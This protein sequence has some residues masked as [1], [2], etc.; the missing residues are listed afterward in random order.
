MTD[1]IIKKDYNKGYS[2]EFDGFLIINLIEKEDNEYLIIELTDKIKSFYNL[3]NNA[4]DVKQFTKDYKIK[5]NLLHKIEC[6]VYTYY[7]IQYIGKPT[8]I[9]M[10]LMNCLMINN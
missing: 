5:G 6:F 10:K 1:I 7:D 8:Y 3:K 4:L 9:Y 2:I